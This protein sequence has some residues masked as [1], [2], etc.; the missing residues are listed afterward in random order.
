[1]LAV[2]IIKSVKQQ[3][4]QSEKEKEITEN[5]NSVDVFLKC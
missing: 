3:E 1:M 4:I 2:T 5:L